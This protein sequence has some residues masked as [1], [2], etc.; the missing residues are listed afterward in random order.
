MSRSFPHF[1]FRKRLLLLLIALLLAGCST[2]HFLG[3]PLTQ[4]KRFSEFTKE[5][6][7]SELGGNTLNLH[8][9]VANPENYGICQEE[10][11]L[12]SSDL[13]SRMLS[14]SACE[15]YRTALRAFDRN[16]LSASQQL[17]YDI[18]L[19]YLNTELDASSLLLYD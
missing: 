5:V 2:L 15:N 18:F 17:T 19:D 7:C 1:N 3:F 10:V 11:S 14:L 13:Q 12:G 9:T 16:E 6:F 8:Y 4:E